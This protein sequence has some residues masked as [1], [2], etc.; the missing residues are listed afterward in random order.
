MKKLKLGVVI[1]LLF[2]SCKDKNKDKVVF[3]NTL[4]LGNWGTIKNDHYQEY[5]FDTESMYT[6]DPYSGNTLQ[7]R[8][9]LRNDSILRYFVH[10]ELKNQEYE[11][12]S[13][14]VKFDS[15]Q[16]NLRNKTLHR[17]KNTNTLE[18]FINKK[19]DPKV[20]YDSSYRREAELKK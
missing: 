7:Y 20:Y 15:N 19:I 17:L 2:I 11:F 5:Y 6:Y 1:L 8:Y 16:M 10:S 9:V 3:D 14:V 18:M 13:R 12:Y 4:L